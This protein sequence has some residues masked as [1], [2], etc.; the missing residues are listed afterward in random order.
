[1]RIR[2]L[3]ATG[4]LTLGVLA[5]GL[6]FGVSPALAGTGHGPV[7]FE[8]GTNGSGD[9]QLNQPL[10]IA[11]DDDPASPSH[12]DVYVADKNNGRVE[13]FTAAGV[14]ESQF[15]GSKA[16]GGAFSSPTD[17]A[18]DPHTGDVWVVDWGHSVVEKFNS[19]GEYAGVQLTGTPAGAALTGEAPF[20]GPFGVAV[21]PSSGD[22]YVTDQGH[23]VVD[24][25]TSAGVYESQFKENSR[26]PFGLA[27]DLE[28]NV[29]V[30]G[31]REG[32]EGVQEFSSA[33]L[34]KDQ[35]G[36]AGTGDVAV[37]PSSGDVYV[38]EANGGIPVFQFQA[39]PSELAL[40]YEFG[41]HPS[42]PSY[43]LAV[44]LNGTIYL[45]SWQGDVVQVFAAGATATEPKTEAA[46]SVEG[47]TV[48]LNGELQGGE[49]GYYVAYNN[50]GS[51][52]GAGET[53]E[54]AATG[55]KKESATVEGLEPGTKYTFCIAATNAYGPEFGPPLP[56]TTKL[57]VPV[58]EEVSSSGI[59]PF[60]ATLKAN[61]NPEKQD[62]KCVFQY[63]KKGEPYGPEVPCEP[64]DLGSGFGRQAATLHLENLEGGTTYQYRVVVKNPT[65][66]SEGTG[67]FTTAAALVPAIES[68]AVSVETGK[69][70]EPRAVT[71]AAQVNP[72]L[73]ETTS[74]VFDY[75]KLG[76]P[77]EASA[78]CEPSETFGRNINTAQGVHADVKGLLAGVDYHYCVVAEDKTGK[79]ECKDQ[80]FGPPAAVTGGVLSEVPGVAPGT[81]APIGGEVNP[82]SLE[83]RYYVEYGETEA[84]GQTAPF[85]PPGIKLPLGIDAGSGGKPVVLGGK[86]APPDVSLEALTAGAT[87]HYRLVAYNADGTVPGKDK[88]VEVLP[89]P[90]VGPAS[91]SEVTQSSATITTS[92]NPEG[93]HTLY[94]LDVGT[95]TAYGTPYPGDAGSGSAQVPLTFNLSG[96][97]P[98]T[99]YHFRLVASNGDGTGS[100]ADQTFTT[101]AT[102]AEL[103]HVFEVPASP[104]LLSFTALVFPTETG[105]TTT[106]PLTN[107]Q[108]LANALKACRT[109]KN[110]HKRAVCERAARKKYAVKA[111]RTSKRKA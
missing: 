32:S 110:K 87:Y 91:V 77:Y 63:A 94:K 15:N 109:K 52:K 97:E 49:S 101:A 30:A 67:A 31:A 54:G 47:N 38:D 89:A 48:T 9:G 105:T 96:L 98:G 12:G 35:L 104:P 18:V 108:K 29:Y 99:T 8:F 57:V 24:K 33:G 93:L 14:Y 34:F 78:A 23:S 84:Y 62:T 17:V 19:E 59:A 45:A 40:I 88:T 71:F 3:T 22:V 74:C 69:E 106:K 10:G 28:G 42:A 100:E 61:V 80:V 53:P 39:V 72:E 107:A 60:E 11:V 46:T 26:Q 50:N 82:E 64:A 86:G 83:T 73:Q 41:Y 37:D 111:S 79:S 95:S 7:T 20:A 90:Q 25:F 70:A 66:K 102:A 92:V 1:M 16:P 81:T 6:A 4:L 27:V 2:R 5:A 58:V 44:S 55:I 21:D 103:L 43:G 68:E 76:K 65:G 51:C 13:K 75:G 85:L 56:F 36:N